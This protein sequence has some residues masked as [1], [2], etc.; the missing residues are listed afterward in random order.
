MLRR[1]QLLKRSGVDFVVAGDKPQDTMPIKGVNGRFQ[2][3]SCQ[4]GL[5][6]KR[7]K[8]GPRVKPG[9]DGGEWG[10]EGAGK[11]FPCRVQGRALP[12]GDF[13]VLSGA[14]FHTQAS[15]PSLATTRVRPAMRLA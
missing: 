8:A 3:K 15:R 6:P 11:S 10:I 13:L 4:F 9:G 1:W 12:A 7:V 14:Y 5:G 2:A